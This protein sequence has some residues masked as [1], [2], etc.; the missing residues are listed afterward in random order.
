METELATAESAAL[1]CPRRPPERP[2]RAQESPKSGQE[3]PKIGQE[4]P[5]SG[6]ERPGEPQE[7]NMSPRRPQDEP[8]MAK[9]RSTFIL[10]MLF[11]I[12]IPTSSPDIS[13][14]SIDKQETSDFTLSFA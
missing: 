9:E 12:I 7:E 13:S 14:I 8:R 11:V 10:I 4:R 3:S 5:K 2:R 6:Q 1:E